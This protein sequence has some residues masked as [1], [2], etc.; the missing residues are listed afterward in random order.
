M[1]PGNHRGLSGGRGSHTLDTP[2]VAFVRVGSL[3]KV[4]IILDTRFGAF[5]LSS[6]NTISDG[7]TTIITKS[8]YQ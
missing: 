4:L 5:T 2:L 7:I 1:L 8:A 6:K 3:A